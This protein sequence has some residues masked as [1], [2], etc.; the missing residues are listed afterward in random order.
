MATSAKYINHPRK[1]EASAASNGVAGVVLVA[2]VA[3]QLVAPIWLRFEN[4]GLQDLRAV[5]T[6]INAAGTHADLQPTTGIAVPAGF[7]SA[8]QIEWSDGQKNT[9]VDRG[10]GFRLLDAAGAAEVV[11]QVIAIQETGVA[12]T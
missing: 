9:A 11:A 1:V 2:R 5:L 7:G 6:Q 10:L 4:R 12:G 8:V 3:D